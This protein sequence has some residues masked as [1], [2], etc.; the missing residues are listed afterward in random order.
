MNAKENSGIVAVYDLG[1]GTFD[2]SILDIEDGVFEVRATN[3]NTHLGG[4]DFDS[5]V[6]N[7]IV[8]NFIKKNPDITKNEI[9]GNREVMQRIREAA[10]KAKITLSHVKQ[11]TIDIP[12]IYHN[13]HVNLTLKETELDEMTMPLIEKTIPPVKKALNCLLYTSRCV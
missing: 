1:G 10:E 11:T 6:V 13:K 9:T 7:H 5:V 3:G 12:F 8:Q 2:I 4:E